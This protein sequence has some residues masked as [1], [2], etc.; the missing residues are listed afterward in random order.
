MYYLAID[1]LY[2]FSR[3]LKSCWAKNVRGEKFD[4]PCGALAPDINFSSISSGRKKNS[5]FV[6]WLS[7]GTEK[8]R[9]FLPLPKVA[10][11]GVSI[12]TIDCSAPGWG[13]EIRGRGSN[14]WG[15]RD[16][17]LRMEGR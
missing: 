15:V 11:Q 4:I 5:V 10:G 8:T 3:S 6:P 12:T 16:E 13:T 7:V 2:Y 1:I 17:A 9:L 14:P